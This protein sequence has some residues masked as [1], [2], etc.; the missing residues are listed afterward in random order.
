M[1]KFRT[2][3]RTRPIE[4]QTLGSEFY[5]RE[6]SKPLFNSHDIMTVHHVHK[7][8]TLLLLFKVLKLRSPFNLYECFNM[9]RRKTTLIITPSPS[10]NF[11][12]QAS[13]MWNTIRSIVNIEDFSFSTSRFK[14]ILKKSILVRQKLGDPIEWSEE[15]FEL[16]KL[17]M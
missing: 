5:A 15:N 7:Y 12:Y 14:F 10:T 13:I 1:D 17:F 9:S 6:N 11:V 2:S 4:E 3:V 16:Q 8:H